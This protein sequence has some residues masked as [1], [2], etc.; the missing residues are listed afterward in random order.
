[1]QLYN[2][3]KYF[4]VILKVRLLFNV[5]IKSLIINRDCFLISKKAVAIYTDESKGMLTPAALVDVDGD[6]IED[7][8]IATFNS[9]VIAF[10]I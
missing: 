3:E 7:I 6:Y 1:M 5:V 9:H 4:K 10:F 2:T 8:V